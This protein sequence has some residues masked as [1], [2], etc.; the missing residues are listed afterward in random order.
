MKTTLRL[1][2][3]LF[4]LLFAVNAMSQIPRYSLDIQNGQIVSPYRITF[5]I[6]LTHTDATQFEF[7]GAQYFL[8]IPLSGFGT[9]SIGTGTN[10]AYQFD[11]SGGHPISDFPQSFWPRNPITQISGDFVEL[12]LASNILPGPGNGLILAQGDSQLVM[13]MKLTSST[14]MNM[15][16]ANFTVNDSCDYHD[17]YGTTTRVYAYIGTDVSPITRCIDHH[18]SLLFPVAQS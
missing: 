13:R 4:I 5:D 17:F 12:G 9:F 6:V 3:T 1:F 8:R 11:S 16:N 2:A 7:A 15:S 18:V 14:P 10:S